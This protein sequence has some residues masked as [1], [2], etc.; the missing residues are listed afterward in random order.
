MIFIIVLLGIIT[1]FIFFGYP[2]ETVFDEVHFGKFISGYFTGNYFFDIHPPLGKLIIAGFGKIT[3]FKANFSFEKIGQVFV[4]QNYQFL[5]FPPKL[6]GA[7]IPF[8]IFLISL[9]LG[10][11]QKLSFLISLSI[12]FEN[13]LIAQ[14]RFILLD[15]FMLLFGFLG[16]LFYLNWKEKRNSKKF[17]F[18]AGLFSGLAGLIKWTGLSFLGII[19]IFYFLNLFKNSE[20]IVYFLKGVIFLIIIP[21]FVYL[22]VFYIHFYLLPNNGP[23]AAFH[24]PEFQKTLIGNSYQK[25]E[26]IKPLNNFEKFIELNKEMYLKNQNLNATHPYSSNWYSWP[27]MIRPIYYWNKIFD[28]DHYGRIYFIGNPV[29]WW[30]GF[31]SIIYLTILIIK[32]IFSRRQITQKHL[33]IIT[34]YYIN[35]LP[36][37][38]IKRVMFLYHY[39]PALIFSIISFGF[40]NNNLQKLF[41]YLVIFAIL[42]FIIFSPLTYGLKI[43]ERYY[44]LLVWL[45]TWK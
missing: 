22:S 10:F 21:F 37:I 12:I 32:N 16:I 31:T 15:S 6:A 27:L 2:N 26:E 18:F 35:L 23:G 39:L 1:R 3:G 8:I 4:D 29:I 41:K 38:F 33:L 13:S 45:S 40:L 9:K 19:L 5:R 7:I 28:K 34:S 17:L 30:F 43:P 25:V 20:K 24:T 36:F 14:S 42:I 11:N 44:N